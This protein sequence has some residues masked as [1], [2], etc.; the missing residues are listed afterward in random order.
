MNV[1]SMV[2]GF[3]L[4]FACTFTLSL[5]KAALT[6]SVESTYQ[7]HVI[8][9]RK[10]LSSY[11]SLCYDRMRGEQK[12]S[13][14]N[15]NTVNEDENTESEEKKSVFINSECARLN[16]WPLLQD[17]KEK[18]LLLYETTAQLLRCFYA[19]NLLKEQP[20][21]EYQI[22][23]AIIDSGKAALKDPN[24][25]HLSLEK[26]AIKG[27]VKQLYPLQTVYYRMLRGTKKQSGYPSLVDYFVIE[28]KETHICLHHA[29]YPM[30]CALF[31]EKIAPFLQHE[32][33]ESKVPLL[34]ERIREICSQNGRIGLSDEFLNMLD[35][36]SSRHHL[37][38][39]K[40]LIE[41]DAD[42]CLKQR[43]YLPS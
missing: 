37:S 34:P 8:A 35:L 11:E 25:A 16:L 5:R 42:V 43:V 29:S 9:S 26:L 7:A 18:Q 36:N 32:I 15:E 6:K 41:E 2:M 3:L 23:D 17:G 10:I 40:T 13:A 19:Q 38:G 4:I 20:R 21:L 30:L 22:L 28:N 14:P 27:N 39:Q 31:G 1:L 12:K 33:H 24:L